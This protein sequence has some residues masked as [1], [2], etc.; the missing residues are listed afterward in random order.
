MVLSHKV[1]LINDV[2]TYDPEDVKQLTIIS[3]PSDGQ[4]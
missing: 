2:T 1:R 4:K 3:R